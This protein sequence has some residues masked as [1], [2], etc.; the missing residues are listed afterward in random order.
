M[1]TTVDG[2]GEFDSW[3]ICR[4]R[5]GAAIA[6]L[7]GT[8]FI[9]FV[10]GRGFG[11]DPAFLI[12]LLAVLLF[13]SIGC[14]L[15]GSLGRCVALAGAVF[16][17]AFCTALW[18]ANLKVDSP[19]CDTPQRGSIACQPVS[20]APTTSLPSVIADP[21]KKPVDSAAHEPDTKSDEYTFPGT[22]KDGTTEAGT[23][24]QGV[25]LPPPPV[26]VPESKPPRDRIPEQTI[27]ITISVGG[28]VQ[29]LSGSKKPPQ[30]AARP[31]PVSPVQPAFVPAKPPIKPLQNFFKCLLLAPDRLPIDGSGG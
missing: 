11:Q 18:V 12:C 23:S 3:K 31:R 21:P 24:Q 20:P 10:K 26:P 29:D 8:V 1:L 19:R 2:V 6:G 30:P 15:P 4:E 27:G 16:P 9:E 13:V 5:V 28:P 7:A 17:V 14:L 25:A 22:R